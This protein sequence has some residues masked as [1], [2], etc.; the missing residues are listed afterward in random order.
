MLFQEK[1]LDNMHDAVVF[2]DRNCKILLWNRGAERLTG[3]TSTAA[4]QQ[5][6][7]PRLVGLHDS[8][9]RVVTQTE[10]PVHYA[11]QTG[12]QSLRRL[13]IRGRH[14]RQVSVDLHTVPVIGPDGLTHGATLLLHDASP[15]ASLEQHCHN[16]HERATK[17][18]LTQVANRA[19]FDRTH[20]LFVATHLEQQAALQ[21]D[22]LR[23]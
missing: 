8:D 4:F 16:L 10:C 15:E 13:L 17:D 18:P 3:I 2:V 9:G 14:N 23:H 5:D 6:F 20:A 11:I 7:V 12:V 22:H 19:E 21:L 1:L